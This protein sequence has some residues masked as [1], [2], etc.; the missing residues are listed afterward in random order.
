M[1]V[2]K[3]IIAFLLVL[4]VG[5]KAFPY[6]N[7]WPPKKSNTELTKTNFEIGG[8]L[9]GSVLYLSRNIKEGNDALGYSIV[10]NYGGHKLLRFSLQYT[11]YK[12]INIEPT[13]YT[14][15]ANTIEANVEIIAR[16]KNNKTFL[17]PF[18]GL[19]HNTFKGF[20]TGQ[21]DYLNL[22]EHYKVNT[23]IVNNWIGL[24]VGTGFEHAFGPVV[25]FFDYRMRVG[26]TGGSGSLNIM[27]V[28]YGGGL[29]LKL[30][31]PT[32]RSSARHIFHFFNNRYHW[33]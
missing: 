20:F 31:V 9:M 33:F 11:Y 32:I 5:Y 25:V 1:R 2:T 15:R 4:C 7:N 18:L 3:K 29:R 21:N 24:N 12:P 8:G 30:Y 17:Y 16:F 28:C 26:R 22:R 14:I 10:A 6:C 23:N 13:W 27:D 19:S